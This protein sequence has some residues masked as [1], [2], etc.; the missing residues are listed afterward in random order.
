MN[1]DKGLRQLLPRAGSAISRIVVLAIM[2][3]I[4]FFGFGAY[5]D[6]RDIETEAGA[7]ISSIR[8]ALAEHAL[9]VFKTHQLIAYSVRDRTASLSWDGIA[10][11][12]DLHGYLATIANDFPE[13]QAIWLI[14]GDGDLR[15]SSDEFPAS[16]RGFGDQPSFI[17][18]RDGVE[19][20]TV[21]H[22]KRGGMAGVTA[23]DDV[24]S[25]NFRRNGSGAAFDGLIRIAISPRYFDAFYAAAYADEGV[26]ALVH[27]DGTLLMR[28]PYHSSLAEYSRYDLQGSVSSSHPAFFQDMSSYPEGL[29]TQRSSV[30]GVERYYGYAKIA[31]YPVY[32]GFG[33]GQQELH[34]LWRTRLQSYGAYFIP[35]GF[36]LLL[37]SLYAWRSHRDLE[38]IVEL[39]T[40]ALSSAIAEKNQLLKEVHHRVKNNMQIIS[41]LIRMQE[42]VQTSPN[43]TIRRVQAMALV[44]DLIY[45]HDEFASVNLAAY[46]HRMLDTLRSST[47]ESIVFDLDLEPVTVALDRAMPFA[48]ILSEIVTNATRHAF[49]EGRGTVAISLR[50][51]GD[52]IEL[53]VNDDGIGHNPEVDGRGFGMR[54]VKSLAVQLEA[55]I[56]FARNDG[57]HFRMTFPIDAQDGNV[58]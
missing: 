30:D 44:H 41:S 50:R 58:A 10:G 51:E 7:R 19:E 36:V 17:A 15:A 32:V 6:W 55:D 35:T 45:S 47:R 56:D 39:R 29:L 4:L 48:L 13:V 42:R 38:D 9:R 5:R 54:L 49:P 23:E 33:L 46:A 28:Y 8:D 52:R 37:L 12:S 43:E 11:S 24:F 18:L 2:L 31:D 26:I 16:T 1:E 57:T 21:G 27:S 40:A 14:D 20:V 3:P 34:R 22:R 53:S 25:I